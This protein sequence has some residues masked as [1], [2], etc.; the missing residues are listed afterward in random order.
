[1]QENGVIPSVLIVGAGNIAGRFDETR[2]DAG[3]PTTHAGAYRAHGGYRLAA[4]VEPDAGRRH[5]FAKH[6]D[7]PRAASDFAGLNASAG[8]FDVISLCS[9]TTLH[10][11]HL[12]AAIA[13]RPKA[14]F[15]EKPLAASLPEAQKAVRA[16]ADAGVLLAVNHTRRWAPDV[17]RLASELRDGEWG[18]IRSVSC[19]YNK[20]ILNNGSHMIDLLRLLLD[21]MALAW[22]GDPVD[23][24][25]PDDPSIP[26]VLKTGEGIPVH[27]G[28]GH[29]A[30]YALFE[31][32]LHTSRGVIAMEDGGFVWRV[33]R[34]Q[35]SI[36]FPGYRSLDAGSSTEGRYAQ[37][38]LSAAHNLAQVL[39]GNGALACDGETALGS[40]TLS[41]AIL[42]QAQ[43]QA[44]TTQKNNG[45]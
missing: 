8:E 30:D 21:E 35:D 42:Q 39:R 19:V 1:M 27:L 4:V 9:P 40:L 24:F 14:I 7:I 15:C 33:R 6:W 41:H 31:L 34:P 13:L 44:A 3:S 18:V 43:T 38:M 2:T 26:A 29:A 16:A 22:V 10:A 25:W 17:Q 37:A 32:Q 11:D 45:L 12:A 20:G 5:A 23:D 36:R 28:I